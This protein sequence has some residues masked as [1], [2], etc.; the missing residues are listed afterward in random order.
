ME[1]VQIYRCLC[2]TT[3][4][5]ILNLLGCR[6]LCV[7][8]LQEILDLPQ[9]KVSQHLAYLRKH[10]MVECQRSGTWMVYRLPAQVPDV[11]TR[12]LQCLQ[13]C[14]QTDPRMKADRKALAKMKIGMQ[15][16]SC[17]ASK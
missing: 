15:S 17:V 11:L 1:L 6:P 9:T 5:R 16:Q 13:D 7:C 2:D 3:R 12:H 8:H 10:G 4:L 14:A